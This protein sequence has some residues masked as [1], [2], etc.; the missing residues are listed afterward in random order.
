MMKSFHM[1]AFAGLFMLSACVTPDYRDV[2]KADGEIKANDVNFKVSSTF[3]RDPPNCVAVMDGKSNQHPNF[4]KQ[5]SIAFAR[6][7]GEKIDRVI[8][9]RK[10][11][12]IER[13]DGYDLTNKGDRRRFSMRTKCRFYAV[14]ELYD[15]GDDYAGVFAKKHVGIKLDVMRIEDDEPLWQAAHTVWRADGN[16]PMN[17]FSAIGG[18][19]SATLF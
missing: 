9:P 10:R 4:A 13:R 16:V 3:Y 15:L 12:Q 1:I 5:V 19:T 6:H 7:L 2:G 14:A 8:F 17:P 18:I 11:Q